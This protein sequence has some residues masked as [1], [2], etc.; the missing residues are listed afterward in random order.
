MDIASIKHKL[1]EDLG[2]V[3]KDAPEA[4]NTIAKTQTKEQTKC[5]GQLRRS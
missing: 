5:S 1:Y 4:Q 3:V 2:H